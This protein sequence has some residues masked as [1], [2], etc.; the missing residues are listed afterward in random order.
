MSQHQNKPSEQIKNVAKSHPNG[1]VYQIEGQYAPSEL[2]PSESIV[3]AWKVDANGNIVGDFIANPNYKPKEQ[4]Q[5][6]ENHK[7]SVD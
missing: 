4:K 1:W 3:G 2:V 5:K 7:D 6:K